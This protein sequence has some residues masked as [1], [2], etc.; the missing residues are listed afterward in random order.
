M[1]LNLRIFA[2]AN[3]KR[4]SLLPLGL[5]NYS[6]LSLVLSMAILAS[7]WRR[8]ATG[9][10]EREIYDGFIWAPGSSCVWNF[11]SKALYMN[12]KY[13]FIFFNLKL[14][15]LD[16]P[17]L[18]TK[19]ILTDR[20]II[21]F[22]FTTMYVPCKPVISLYEV[23]STTDLDIFTRISIVFTDLFLLW[24]I[25]LILVTSPRLWASG[26]HPTVIP[27]HSLL[28]TVRDH[29]SDSGS[30]TEFQ[31]TF[32]LRATKLGNHSKHQPT[33]SVPW[34]YLV[35]VVVSGF[36][37]MAS[38]RWTPLDGITS[39]PSWALYLHNVFGFYSG[40]L[41]EPL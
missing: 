4:L 36:C 1:R 8:E 17:F 11:R 3:G 38:L 15:E 40:S 31:C 35:Y 14:F 26:L 39:L 24:A 2:E 29:C 22:I 28:R 30:V 18:T 6:L 13:L 10:R 5:L 20:V 27:S 23:S 9:E 21:V 25:F 33:S 19:Q 7:T 37:S 41:F 12:S 34:S 32:A 16:F